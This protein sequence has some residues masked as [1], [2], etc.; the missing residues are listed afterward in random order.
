MERRSGKRLG[1][2]NFTTG[3]RRKKRKRAQLRHG[4]L[5]FRLLR[6]D[7][8]LHRRRCEVC[9]GSS[10]KGGRSPRRCTKTMDRE[11]VPA[12]M[13]GT[14][15]GLAGRKRLVDRAAALGHDQRSYQRRPKQYFA[16][17]DR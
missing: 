14:K 15:L 3:V 7:A 9:V 2:A 1:A 10:P 12:S 11:V 16:E 8:D 13:V 4:G 17:G 6:I 5:C